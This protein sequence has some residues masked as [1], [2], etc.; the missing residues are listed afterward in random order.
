MVYRGYPIVQDEDTLVTFAGVPGTYAPV[1]AV[2]A[3]TVVDASGSPIEAEAYE[4][5]LHFQAE[6]G[7]MYLLQPQE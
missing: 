6:G 2:G 4:S 7:K 5:D 3:S 1:A